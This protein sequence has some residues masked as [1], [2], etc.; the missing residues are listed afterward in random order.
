MADQIPGYRMR[1]QALSILRLLARGPVRGRKVLQKLLYFL[2]EAERAPLGL[3]FKMY[4]Y[5]PYSATLDARLQMLEASDL[6]AIDWDVNQVPTF[7]VS[8]AIA[9]KLQQS[10]DLEEKIQH[11]I[12]RFG[13]IARNPNQLELLATLHYLAKK[14]QGPIEPIKLVAQVQ[15]WKGPKFSK[16]QVEQALR[17]LKELDYL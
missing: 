13:D 12:G 16:L 5:G 9:E 1:P 7:S 2:Q 11:V 3:D 6:I 14:Q 17:T 10:A 4:L 15:A 8:Q